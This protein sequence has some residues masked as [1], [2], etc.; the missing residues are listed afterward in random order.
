MYAYVVCL[1]AIVAIGFGAVTL[2]NGTFAYLNPL[3]NASWNGASLS[4]YEAFRSTYDASQQSSAAN[5]A[6]TT[7]PDD[8]LRSQYDT[9]RTDAIVAAQVDALRTLVGGG[10]LVLIAL[11]VFRF[12]WRW[13]ERR[14]VASSWS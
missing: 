9:R 11:I 1:V 6:P 10:V 5:P 2:V 14:G 7:P 12:H 3:A 4:S 13:L 8:Q